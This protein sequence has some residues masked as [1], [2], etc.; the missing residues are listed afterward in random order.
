MAS[1]ATTTITTRSKFQFYIHSGGSQNIP[2]LGWGIG[3]YNAGVSITGR[4]TWNSPASI[5]GDAQ[6]EPLRQWALDNFG[7][8]LLA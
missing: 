8:D 7:E 4:R 5:S 3:V 6:T 2:E 1:S